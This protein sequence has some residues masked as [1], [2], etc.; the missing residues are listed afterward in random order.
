MLRSSQESNDPR[1][2]IV[3]QVFSQHDSTLTLPHA[4]IDYDLEIERLIEKSKA[5]MLTVSALQIN[6]FTFE[7]EFIPN[8]LSIQ[9]FA[10]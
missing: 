1:D 6:F 10:D 8:I 2:S 7:W 4:N 3:P 5:R 9:F